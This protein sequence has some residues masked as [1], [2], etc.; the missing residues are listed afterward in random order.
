VKKFRILPKE[1]DPEE[2]DTTP[3]RKIRRAHFERMFKDLIDDMYV[4]E[5]QEVQQLQ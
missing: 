1:L 2:G 5:R 4:D 3:T